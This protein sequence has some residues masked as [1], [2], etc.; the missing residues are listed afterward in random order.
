M[1]LPEVIVVKLVK[2]EVSLKQ[3]LLVEK[4]T[5]GVGLMKIEDCELSLH[6]FELLTT[7]LTMYVPD[8]SKR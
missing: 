5:S 1:I 2:K 3:I 6:P 4:E 8:V 7:K